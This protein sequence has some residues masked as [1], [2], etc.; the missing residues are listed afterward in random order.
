MI[1]RLF[2][3]RTHHSPPEGV[4]VALEVD[5]SV[6]RD[7]VLLREVDEVAG[8]D[9]AEEADV[10][11]CDQLLAVNE[12]DG[13]EE[14]P[15]AGLTVHVQHPQDLK[16]PDAPDGRGSEHLAA[17][18]FIF[19]RFFGVIFGQLNYPAML[20]IFHRRTQIFTATRRFFQCR[21]ECHFNGSFSRKETYK[22]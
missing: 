13:A 10:E 4:G 3:T 20:R 21:R 1:A 11:G 19:G 16:E 8:E 9:Q 22:K 7:G 12:D 14:A 17:A 6:G 2:G 15:G 18:G 5:G